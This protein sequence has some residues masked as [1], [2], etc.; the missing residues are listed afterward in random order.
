[1]YV[2]VLHAQNKNTLS[3]E[4]E[5]NLSTRSDQYAENKL[6]SSATHWPLHASL[7]PLSASLEVHLVAAGQFPAKTC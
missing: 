4:T 6:R 5:R 7:K 3:F 2:Y 1:M